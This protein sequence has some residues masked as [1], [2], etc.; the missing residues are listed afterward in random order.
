MHTTVEILAAAK[1]RLSIT[2]DYALAKKLGFNHSRVSNY[3]RGVS[4]LDN[5]AAFKIAAVL[6]ESPAK[7]IA[8]VE[9]ERART[10]EKRKKWE[11]I[12]RI[13]VLAWAFVLALLLSTPKTA[14]AAQGGTLGQF[15]VT[16][17]TLCA[18]RRVLRL[19]CKGA[20]AFGLGLWVIYGAAAAA[21]ETTVSVLHRVW[22]PDPKMEWSFDQAV[23]SRDIGTRAEGMAI[24]HRWKWYQINAAYLGHTEER[25]TGLRG[26]TYTGRVAETDQLGFNVAVTPRIGPFYAKFGTWMNYHYNR[27][28]GD[29]F[30]RSFS[31]RHTG[32]HRSGEYG[33][34]VEGKNW[35]V[36]ISYLNSVYTRQ[37]TVGAEHRQ[38]YMAQLGLKLR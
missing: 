23:Y 25:F 17:Y 27:E 29:E 15:D 33:I 38:F 9:A 16:R 21:G 32:I 26:G 22:Y 30:G 10:P 1:R 18:L 2:S 31:Q 12:A 28:Q 5:D 20:A 19:L 34:G 13:A 24:G 14:V 36:E 37:S 7:I 35:F 3:R 11:Q 8:I 4:Y 6:G